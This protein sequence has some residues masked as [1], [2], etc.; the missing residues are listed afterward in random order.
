LLRGKPL[1]LFLLVT[2][3][4]I[5]CS[6]SAKANPLDQLTFAI[7][8]CNYHAIQPKFTLNYVRAPMYTSYTQEPHLIAGYQI[9][10]ITYNSTLQGTG[11]Q[12]VRY[13]PKSFYAAGNVWVF[14]VNNGLPYYVSSLNGISWTYPM[15]INNGQLV[16]NIGSCINVALDRNGKCHVVLRENTLPNSLLW[17][18]GT[19]LANGTIT[20][21]NS[22]WKDVWD[23]NSAGGTNYDY[24]FALDSSGHDWVTWI[25]NP[26]SFAHTTTTNSLFAIENGHTDGTWLQIRNITIA[27]GTGGKFPTMDFIVPL[28]NNQMLFGYSSSAT[29]GIYDKVWNGASLGA[30]ETIST[31]TVFDDYP[32][33]YESWARTVTEDSSGNVHLAFITSTN[34]LDYVSRAINTGTWSTETTIQ[35]NVTVGASPSLSIYNRA[36]IIY[37]IHDAYH[38]VSQTYSSGSWSNPMV[39]VNASNPIPLFYDYGYNGRL[40][41]FSE[42]LHNKIGLI[43]VENT[44]A[45]GIY[46]VMFDY[47]ASSTNTARAGPPSTSIYVAI[48][49]VII[50]IVA[51]A[52]VA[53]ITQKK[54]RKTQNMRLEGKTLKPNM[55]SIWRFSF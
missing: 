24:Y 1:L 49:I 32:A 16:H 2:T 26:I 9:A 13:Q 31:N 36:P 46:N 14:Y 39:V 17:N 22:N 11:S 8:H 20:W 53:R 27:T 42:Q 25:F 44:T 30:Q 35:P 45:A 5:F 4:L 18:Y 21:A 52:I 6:P 40:N 29:N 47:V 28:L 38:I 55:S 15:L 34:N 43:W 3:I 51:V 7:N 23:F 10:Q 33:A 41:S 48:P 12:A 19:P 54:E 37:Y 50:I